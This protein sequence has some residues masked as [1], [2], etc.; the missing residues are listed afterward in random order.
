MESDRDDFD[1]GLQVWIEWLLFIPMKGKSMMV[2]HK[3]YKYFDLSLNVLTYFIN[4]VVSMKNCDIYRFAE[5]W[6]LALL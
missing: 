4:C 1:V 3:I 6:G 5:F 2:V